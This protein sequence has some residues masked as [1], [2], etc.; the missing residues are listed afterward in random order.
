MKSAPVEP[1]WCQFGTRPPRQARHFEE[2]PGAGGL[3][4]KAQVPCDCD[5]LIA[6]LG[7]KITVTVRRAGRT[8]IGEAFVTLITT[9]SSCEDTGF[10][11]LAH[12]VSAT[13]L[14]VCPTE[15]GT[16]M[17]E[18]TI[19]LTDPDRKLTERESS[20][21]IHRADYPRSAIGGKH[22]RKVVGIVTGW[23]CDLA[24]ARCGVPVDFPPGPHQGRGTLR[25][26]RHYI[27]HLD[28]CADKLVP[29]WRDDFAQFPTAHS[30]PHPWCETAFGPVSRYGRSVPPY[31]MGAESETIRVVGYWTFPMPSSQV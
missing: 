15:E 7:K 26:Y 18:R 24:D 20:D 12:L 31:S 14:T 29:R 17:R 27:A 6:D 25:W 2:I 16:S 11:S 8:R 28:D 23:A 3:Y 4:W 5:E 19:D 9:G 1:V 13:P 22:S 10:T 30:G 21:V